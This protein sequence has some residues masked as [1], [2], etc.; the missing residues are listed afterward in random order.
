M[1]RKFEALKQGNDKLMFKLKE[2]GIPQDGNNKENDKKAVTNV[3]KQK[4]QNYQGKCIY[5]WILFVIKIVFFKI[6]FI[7]IF[8]IYFINFLIN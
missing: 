2:H 8:F 7:Y 3:S 1:T 6:Y 4:I 5:M